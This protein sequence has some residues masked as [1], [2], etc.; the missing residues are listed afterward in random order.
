MLMQMNDGVE[1]IEK[2]WLLPP[3]SKALRATVI[4][5]RL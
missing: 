4:V 1:F 2:R 3:Q 5:F